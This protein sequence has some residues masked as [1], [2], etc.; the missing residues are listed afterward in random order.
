MQFIDQH[1]DVDPKVLD[2]QLVAETVG[3]PKGLAPFVQKN[4]G[5]ELDKGQQRTDWL[6]LPL[7]EAQ[8]R[9]SM[10]M[11]SGLI[12]YT[13]FKGQDNRGPLETESSHVYGQ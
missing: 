6:R 7:T 13:T 10:G 8:I 4:L 3:E 5:A 11:P 12:I 9:Y 2:L 1:T